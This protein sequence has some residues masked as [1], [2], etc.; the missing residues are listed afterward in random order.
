MVELGKERFLV[1]N[2]TQ[3]DILPIKCKKLTYVLD[4]NKFVITCDWER[5]FIDK[6]SYEIIVSTTL[7]DYQYAILNAMFNDYLH[8][9]HYHFSDDCIAIKINS[10]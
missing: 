4:T 5:F 2:N 1:K 7:N 8:R 9:I 6:T 10:K 3:E